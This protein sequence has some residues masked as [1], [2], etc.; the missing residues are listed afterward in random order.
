[1]YRP[2][3]TTSACSDFDSGISTLTIIHHLLRGITMQSPSLGEVEDPDWRILNTKLSR[4]CWDFMVCFAF[5]VDIRAEIF[6][7]CN[8]NVNLKYWIN[9]STVVFTA[10]CIPSDLYLMPCLSLEQSNSPD[11]CH[12]ALNFSL[13]GLQKLSIYELNPGGISGYGAMFPM[14]LKPMTSLNFQ[15]LQIN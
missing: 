4:R 15:Y 7:K 6:F 5:S 2:L 11:E 13:L 14:N 12:N 8:Q 1:M 9:S 3:R 10:V